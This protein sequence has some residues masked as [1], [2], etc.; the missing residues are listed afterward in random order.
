MVSPGYGEAWLGLVDTE[1]LVCVP[2][3]YPDGR[4]REVWYIR[5]EGTCMGMSIGKAVD[6][7]GGAARCFRGVP[8]CREA[9][10][11]RLKRVRE[12]QLLPDQ[13]ESVRQ[14]KGLV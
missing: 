6:M 4:V 1:G 11:M 13:G 9:S 2:C 14:Y 7:G 12:L 3:L 8:A 5:M 10:A